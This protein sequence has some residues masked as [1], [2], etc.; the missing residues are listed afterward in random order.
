MTNKDREHTHDQSVNS[1]PR[2]VV[3]PSGH[4]LLDGA[5]RFAL[6]LEDQGLSANWQDG[7]EYAQTATLPGLL[8][9]HL[10]NDQG[11]VPSLDSV[12]AW[13]ERE[14]DA[15]ADWAD[16]RE[17][18]VQ[19]TFGACGYETRV[20]LN[21]QPLRTVEGEEIH[22]GEYLAFSYELPSEHLQPVNRLTVRIADS[23]DA[24]IPRGKQES[25]VHKRRGIWYQT[26][27]GA[28]R[29]IWIEPVERNRLRSRLA[30]NA[31]IEDNLV[32][33]TLTTRVQDAGAYVLQLAVTQKGGEEPV[34]T[35]D[36][37]VPLEAGE[38][39]QRVV[40]E[41]PDA[42]LWSGTSP[43]LY[44]LTAQL[45][46][47]DGGVSQIE[48][49]FGL[50][51]IEAR[52]R[53]I[54]L[55]N[56]PVYLDGVL[57]QPGISTFE[58]MQAHMHAMQQLGCNLVRIHIAGVDP[59]IYDLADEMGMLLW[60]EVP[61]PHASTER[62][63]TNHHAE[64]MRMLKTILAHPSV[65]IWSMYN[66]DWGVQDIETSEPTRSYIAS[67]YSHMRLNHPQV[68]V[69]DNDGWRHVSTQGRLESDLLTVHMYTPDLDRWRSVL[70]SLVVGDLE[71][72]PG[73][74]LVVGD[75]Y[76]YRGQSPLVLSEWGGFGWSGYKGPQD[77][78]AK[79]ELIREMKRDLRKRAI[80][81]DV[82]TQATSIEE[83][84]NG[85]LDAETGDL[86]VPPGILGP[87]GD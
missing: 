75:P 85:L 54:F 18:I 81:G 14:F 46:G 17:R 57:Y 77:D 16:A 44:H 70:D 68:L 37:P 59:R 67:A 82:Y 42:K 72:R 1:L 48:T 49:Q 41:L 27:T 47:P 50:R 23:R 61:S 25:T 79:A 38:Q 36:Y 7:H 10:E 63:R 69:V 35:A 83:E 9:Q 73:N 6:D 2:S 78:A 66:E 20:W 11:S 15:P 53:S 80:A 86:Q 24:E 55:N 28:V 76:Y 33:F 56:E 5:W 4:V 3:R 87:P 22:E 84:V 21:G 52:G 13:Y 26:I 19:L 43:N 60:V 39:R 64:L 45:R 34:V 30:V 32:E 12:A 71:N 62:S 58:Q 40:L 65:V 8:E 31:T 29:S 51:K 74:P